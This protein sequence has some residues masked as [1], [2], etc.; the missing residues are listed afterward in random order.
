MSQPAQLAEAKRQFEAAALN[1]LVAT[2]RAC[3]SVRPRANWG[4][5]GY[6]GGCNTP[7]IV[8]S[9]RTADEC[10]ADHAK[11]APLFD[12]FTAFFPAIYFPKDRGHGW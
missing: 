12:E 8:W 1:V 9:G 4:L 6:T 3:K 5:F 11:L 7:A 2:L 10:R